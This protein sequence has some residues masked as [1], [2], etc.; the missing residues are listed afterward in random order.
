MSESSTM[1]QRRKLDWPSIIVASLSVLSICGASAT[2]VGTRVS[3]IR[4]ATNAN[5]LEINHIKEEFK[6]LDETQISN[7]RDVRDDLGKINDKLDRLLMGNPGPMPSGTY[8]WSK[9]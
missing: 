6:R 1:S 2:W 4:D 7:Q 9:P 8:K 5:T 3:D